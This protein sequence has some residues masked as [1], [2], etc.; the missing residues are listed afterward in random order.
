MALYLLDALTTRECVPIKRGAKALIAKP[1]APA[2]CATKTDEACTQRRGSCQLVSDGYQTELLVCTALG[3]AWYLI[4]RPLV[5]R[6][7]A[8]PISDWRLRA[9]NSKKNG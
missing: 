6:L 4:F 9:Q 5:L 2:L 3:V 8:R 1:G 7:Q